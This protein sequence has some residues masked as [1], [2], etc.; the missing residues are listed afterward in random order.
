MPGKVGAGIRGNDADGRRNQIDAEGSVRL[1]EMKD[2]RGVVGRFDGGD[3]AKGALFWG[4]VGGIPDEVKGRFDIGGGQRAAIVEA[5]AAAD[6]E[7]VSK[8]VGSRPG[9]GKITAETHLIV[10]L[11]Q[12]AEEESIDALGL[13]IDSE[14]RVEVGGVGFNEE[15]EG[16][17]IVVR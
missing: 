4:F 17:R 14:A 9:F 15:G 11:Q 12:A 5:N 7:N 6:M 10:A 16:G 13:R 3:H 1:A 8:R 2:D